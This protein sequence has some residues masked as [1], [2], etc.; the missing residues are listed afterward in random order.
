MMNNNSKLWPLIF[1]TIIGCNLDNEGF[2]SEMPE[3]F[4]TDSLTLEKDFF[5]NLTI[6]HIGKDEILLESDEC[7][8]LPLCGNF[9]FK[10]DTI[11]YRN[12]PSNGYK[13]YL[14]L[15]SDRFDTLTYTYSPDW[16]DKIVSMG[17]MWDKLDRDSIQFFQLIPVKRP[18][19]HHLAYLKYI[20]LTKGGFRYLTFSS[21]LRDYT[22]SIE[23]YPKVIW[24]SR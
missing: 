16:I 15:N 22:I 20:A 17:L 4:L 11:F 24:T 7:T 14:L 1:L 21:Y 13:P 8:K 5:D 2:F 6:Q 10:N 18:P 12:K 3:S 9:L 23:E 19:P